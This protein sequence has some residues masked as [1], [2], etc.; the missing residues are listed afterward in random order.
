M[1]YL[2]KNVNHLKFDLLYTNKRRNLENA[3]FLGECLK[4][5]PSHLV[6]ITIKLGIDIIEEN[7]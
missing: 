6:Q 5:L 4:Y 1:K 7:Y 3:K 2:P